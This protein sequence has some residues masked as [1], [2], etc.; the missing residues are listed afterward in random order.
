MINKKPTFYVLI[1][2]CLS[3][4]SNAKDDN[5]SFCKTIAQESYQE[6]LEEARRDPSVWQEYG[7]DSAIDYANAR[8]RGMYSICMKKYEK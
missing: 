4:Y 6:G 7:Y 8:K 1:F 2:L 5:K 3:S